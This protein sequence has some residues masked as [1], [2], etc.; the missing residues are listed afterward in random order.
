MSLVKSRHQCYE[1]HP[2]VEMK[3]DTLTRRIYMHAERTVRQDQITTYV[4]VAQEIVSSHIAFITDVC[5]KR[6]RQSCERALSSPRRCP[7]GSRLT[8]PSI[9]RQHHEIVPIGQSHHTSLDDQQVP[10]SRRE[11]TKNAADRQFQ[12][13]NVQHQQQSTEISTFN[14]SISL[15]I[16]D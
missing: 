1:M 3:S 8:F 15:S 7:P 4:H 2:L 6:C 9:G 14:S 13:R 5:T 12:F 11:R 16:F 10:S